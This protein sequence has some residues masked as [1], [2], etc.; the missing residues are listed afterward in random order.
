[1]TRRR[2][3]RKREIGRGIEKKIEIRRGTEKGIGKRKGTE[4]EIEKRRRTEKEIGI[5]IRR[6]TGTEVEVQKRI[7][8]KK[9]TET[10]KKRKLLGTSKEKEMNTSPL[11]TGRETRKSIDIVMIVLNPP[12]REAQKRKR[13]ETEENDRPSTGNSCAIVKQ[14]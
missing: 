6:K 8:M 5:R 3:G 4:K 2:T 1:M 13:A 14:C 7:G 10:E 11:E 9:S 12:K